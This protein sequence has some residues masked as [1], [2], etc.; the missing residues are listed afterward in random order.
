MPLF[1]TMTHICGWHAAKLVKK[2]KFTIIWAFHSA[3]SPWNKISHQLAIITVK[4]VAQTHAGTDLHLTLSYTVANALVLNLDNLMAVTCW[5]DIW[6][7]R[8][9]QMICCHSVSANSTA[10]EAIPS[11]KAIVVKWKMVYLRNVWNVWPLQNTATLHLSLTAGVHVRL[12]T[13]V[14]LQSHTLGNWHL[15]QLSHHSSSWLTTS[16]LHENDKEELMYR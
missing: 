15:L 8:L 13:P 9:H 6:K 5:C 16:P 7:Q 10:K 2:F 14:R 11:K 1:P 3:F 12:V 4:H